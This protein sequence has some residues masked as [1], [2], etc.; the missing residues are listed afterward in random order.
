M[1]GILEE[2]GVQYLRLA[3]SF[4]YERNAFKILNCSTV[5]LGTHAKNEAATV[6]EV[7]VVFI[8]ERFGI[9]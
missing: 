9:G 6:Q 7:S 4:L 2:N 1:V 5:V 8:E 3:R